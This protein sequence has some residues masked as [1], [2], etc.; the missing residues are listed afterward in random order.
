MIDYFIINICRCAFSA[1]INES[2]LGTAS[3]LAFL[4]MCFTSA[5][6]GLFITGLNLPHPSQRSV[7]II[8]LKINTLGFFF[9]QSIKVLADH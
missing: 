3:V 5:A 6:R 2:T 7:V 1:P 9:Q 4:L 8:A